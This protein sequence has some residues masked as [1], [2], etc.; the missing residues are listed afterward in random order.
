MAHTIERAKLGDE[1]ILAYIQTES[2]KN[3]FRDILD[4]ETLEKCTDL[5]RAVGMYRRLLERSV[6]NGYILRIDGKPHGIA[7]WD[8]ARDGTPGCAEILCIHSLPDHWRQGYGSKLMDRVLSDIAEAGYPRVML[9]VFADNARARAFYAAKG[10]TT[11]GVR[12]PNVIP[13][14][15]R[16]ERRL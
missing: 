8:A 5:D 11:E 6:G 16:Y 2:W 4:R 7:W 1:R 10:F 14:E 9:W 12:K 3:A 15:I 13:T